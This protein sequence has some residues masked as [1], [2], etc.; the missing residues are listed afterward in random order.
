ML[1]SSGSCSACLGATLPPCSPELREL[2]KQ[3]KR[4]QM[5]PGPALEAQFSGL[6]ELA[7][8]ALPFILFA[9]QALQPQHHIF[10][11]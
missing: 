2:E 6:N 9:A 7:F 3:A 8:E 5:G 11:V 4:P 1:L 10:G